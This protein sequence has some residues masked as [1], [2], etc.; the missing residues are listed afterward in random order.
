M[1]FVWSNS[2]IQIHP[3]YC[4]KVLMSALSKNKT[5]LHGLPTPST[6]LLLFKSHPIR[7]LLHS[8]F[9]PSHR[10]PLPKPNCFSLPETDVCRCCRTQTRVFGKLPKPELS[11]FFRALPAFQAISQVLSFARCPHPPSDR[12]YL[13]LCCSTALQLQMSSEMPLP[14]GNHPS[15]HR[16]RSSPSFVGL[17]FICD[18]KCVQMFNSCLRRITY[19]K[20]HLISL[21]IPSPLSGAHWY[22]LREYNR[23]SAEYR[24]SC[25]SVCILPWNIAVLL[26][27]VCQQS[28][29]LC[30][31][32][33][34]Y[35]L[36]FLALV[37]ENV[38]KKICILSQMLDPRISFLG[39]ERQL[40]SPPRLFPKSQQAS[41]GS[42]LKGGRKRVLVL[43]TL[44]QG[45][46]GNYPSLFDKQGQLKAF[47]CKI[48]LHETTQS[49]VT[50]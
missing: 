43:E 44:S 3:C 16:M 48:S 13:L 25:D 33:V 40:Y 27:A 39:P 7:R 30:D 24:A 9:L 31:F 20:F 37:K 2:L 45:D 28:L 6:K 12:S 5:A 47:T 46:Q 4:C 14:P 49:L 41:L 18:F 34:K 19:K 17:I 22:L 1:S 35:C 32:K 15:S 11:V 38:K 8:C 36:S 50:V 42:W 23:T 10:A 29:K 21:L 26:S